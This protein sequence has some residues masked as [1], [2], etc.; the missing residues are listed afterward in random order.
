MHSSNKLYKFSYIYFNKFQ[1]ELRWKRKVE[2]QRKQIA[3]E[4]YLYGQRRAAMELFKQ[5]Y[6]KAMQ[7]EWTRF[8]GLYRKRMV[9]V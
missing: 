7:K 2:E 1:A 4:E 8:E 3:K 6:M 5:N 9:V